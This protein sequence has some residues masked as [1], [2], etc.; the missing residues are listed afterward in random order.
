MQILYACANWN[1]HGR[2]NDQLIGGAHLRQVNEYKL[3][4]LVNIKTIR[5]K[6]FYLLKG[7]SKTKEFLKI[8]NLHN[9]FRDLLN[10]HRDKQKFNE[11]VLNSLGVFIIKSYR[12]KYAFSLK[13]SLSFIVI[14]SIIVTFFYFETILSKENNK[15]LRHSLGI[16]QETTVGT[17][18]L[19]S[20]IHID[21][22]DQIQQSLLYFFNQAYDTRQK[23]W[24]KQANLGY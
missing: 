5:Q 6:V 20:E 12:N 2:N 18:T 9:Q 17:Y 11:K 10:L 3:D 8:Q 7:L 14:C 4:A 16:A 13:V 23:F 21:S 15:L 1:E 24:K 22:Q 19:N